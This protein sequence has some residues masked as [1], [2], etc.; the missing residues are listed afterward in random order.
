M[1][2]RRLFGLFLK[3][4]PICHI[5][6]SLIKGRRK[7]SV[8]RYALKNYFGEIYP[9]SPFFL[10][11]PFKRML[12]LKQNDSRCIL[13]AALSLMCPAGRR[14]PLFYHRPPNP[15]LGSPSTALRGPSF[16][17]RTA[18]KTAMK[19]PRLISRKWRNGVDAKFVS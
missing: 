18:G 13:V 16:T 17:G 12:H 10:Q 4:H 9:P 15:W 1:S 14:A 2:E 6:L 5:E 19:S 8:N 3:I 7:G 11:H